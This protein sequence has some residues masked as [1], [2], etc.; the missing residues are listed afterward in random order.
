MKRHRRFIGNYLSRLKSKKRESKIAVISI[1]ISF[2]INNIH[3]FQSLINNQDCKPQY[4]ARLKEIL[5]HLTEILE[6]EVEV[7]I[8][9]LQINHL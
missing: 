9:Y 6:A 1:K 4:K 8:E 2:K 3:K 5:E 7:K